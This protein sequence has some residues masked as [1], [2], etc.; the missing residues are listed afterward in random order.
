MSATMQ[1]PAAAGNY[2]TFGVSSSH[3]GLPIGDVIEILE[4]REMNRVPGSSSLVC[5]VF[6]HAGTIVPVV[7]L[8][9]KLTGS[10]APASRRSC[11]VIVA[12]RQE[13]GTISVG[14]LVDEVH[15]VVEAPGL[16]AAPSFGTSIRLDYLAGLLR[17]D[18]GLTIVLAADRFLSAADLMEVSAA[19]QTNET[20][21][22]EN[23]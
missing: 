19:V 13:R 17:T 21:T 5:G 14:L 15:D 18:R 20:N 10:P 22:S 23:S 1:T 2:L 3:Y 6:N 7:D 8:H 9:A 16:E 4:S 11:I 12:A